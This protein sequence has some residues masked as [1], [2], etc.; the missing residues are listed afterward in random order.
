VKGG[1]IR[2]GPIDDGELVVTEGP[3]DG[4]SLLQCLSRPV[5]VAAGASMLPSMRF[6]PEIRRVAVAGDNDD[7]GKIAAVKT[8]EAF[9]LRG[10]AARVFYPVPPAKD[11]NDQL[12]RIGA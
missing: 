10:V 9:S 5:W 7:A 3:E 8:A 6:P 11:F 12:M 1:A 2:L 4:L